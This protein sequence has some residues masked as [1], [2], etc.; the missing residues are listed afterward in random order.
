MPLGLRDDLTDGPGLV[1]TG[2]LDV[3]ETLHDHEH[4]V[5][6]ASPSSSS[7]PLPWLSMTVTLSGT[8][9]CQNMRAVVAATTWPEEFLVRPSR[10]EVKLAE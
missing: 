4:V 2:P 7:T 9:I 3:V 10:R 6:V 1:I 8:E 5:E